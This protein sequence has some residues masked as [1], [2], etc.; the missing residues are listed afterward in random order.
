[1]E[2]GG[3]IFE[4]R[5]EG[6]S[7][8]GFEFAVG[9]RDKD[10]FKFVREELFNERDDKIGTFVDALFGDRVSPKDGA[11]D[12]DFSNQRSGLGSDKFD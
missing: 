5:L 11:I 10:R 1:M 12:F 7:E 8:N 6:V 2:L 3:A 4:I 9:L